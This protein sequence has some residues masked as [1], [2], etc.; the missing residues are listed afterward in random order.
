MAQR[1]GRYLMLHPLATGGMGEI[2]LAEHTG[3]SGFAKRVVIKR[4]RPSYAKDKKYVELFMNEARVGSFLNHPN[5]VHIFDVGQEDDQLWLVMEHVEGVDLKRLT[6]RTFLA[7]HALEQCTVAAIFIE[8]L[9]ALEEAHRGGPKSK[10]PIIH[11][12]LSPENILVT[13]TGAVKVLDFGLAKWSP[14]KSSVSSLEGKQIIGKTRYMPPEQLRGGQLDIRSDL[15]SLG[16]VLYQALTNRLAFGKGQAPEI[17]ASILSGPPPSP[18]EICEHISPQL[19][20]IV[21]KAIQTH[22]K[23]RF[24][25]A[26]EMRSALIEFVEGQAVVFPLEPLR[27]LLNPNQTDTM[28]GSESTPFILDGTPTEIG[29]CVAK[30]CGKC[31]GEFSARLHHGLIVDRCNSCGGIWLDAGETERIIGQAIKQGGP[32]RVSWQEAAELDQLVGS[33]PSCRVGLKSYSVPGAKASFEI[34]GLCLGVWLDKREIQLL[35]SQDVITWF[36]T[37]LDSIKAIKSGTTA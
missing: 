35:E 34:C 36:R 15:F 26:N 20:Q 11:R 37:L 1:L 14:G 28:A 16:I 21:F 10:E 31:G 23:D 17:L 6:R 24:Q 13:Q 22:P 25:D 3:L 19:D 5:I 30:R 4:I 9:N 32:D 7:G 8:V 18:S 27:Q 12:D 33:C 2:Y 29:L